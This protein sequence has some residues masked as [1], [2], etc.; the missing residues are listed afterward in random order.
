M[1][2]AEDELLILKD[3]L[4]QAHEWSIPM[5]RKPIKCGSSPAWMN[6]ELL[7]KL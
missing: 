5:G 4:L 1:R 6:K 3:H 7:T 2:G